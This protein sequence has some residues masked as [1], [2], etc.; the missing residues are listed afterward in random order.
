MDPSRRRTLASSGISQIPTSVSRPTAASRQ[1]L[2]PTSSNNNRQSLAPARSLG[3]SRQSLAPS[4]SQELGGSQGS[5]LFSQGHGGP[6]REAPMT[7]GRS[8]MYSSMGSASV[9]RSGVL[10]SSHVDAPYAPPRSAYSL[11]TRRPLLTRLPLAV[12]AAP[13]TIAAQQQQE[14]E[15]RPSPLSSL[16]LSND[17]APT[18][19]NLARSRTAVATPPTSSPSSPPTATTD[20]PTPRSS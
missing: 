3:A 1:S 17:H 15:R 11:P 14:E 20:P 16:P 7:G 10:K 12:S 19:V 9:G 8:N 4:G 18:L 13:R 2:A 5:Q 6:V